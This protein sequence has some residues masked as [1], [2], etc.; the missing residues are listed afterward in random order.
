MTPLEKSIQLVAKYMSILPPQTSTPF[1]MKS[2]A[3]ICALTCVDNI[4]SAIP[5]LVSAEGYGIALF[6]NP[7]FV[8]WND[9]KKEL[10]NFYL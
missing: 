7:D 9:V 10:E 1:D 2:Y 4:L 5:K 8:F 3:L 6:N